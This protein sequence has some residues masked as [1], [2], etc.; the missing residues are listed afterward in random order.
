MFI[1]G[2]DYV[3]VKHLNKFRE[4]FSKIA[5]DIYIDVTGDALCMVFDQRP[6][7]YKWIDEIFY[8]NSDLCYSKQYI[9]ENFNWRI[10]EAY[11]IQFRELCRKIADL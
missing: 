11:R 4:E 2:A 6:D 1:L 10:P 9:E 8:P 3:T 7:L 5:P